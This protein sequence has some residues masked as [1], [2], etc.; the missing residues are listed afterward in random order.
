MVDVSFL[1]HRLMS[2]SWLQ[3]PIIVSVRVS[4]GSRERCFIFFVS[5]ERLHDAF[6]NQLGCVRC[7]VWV[8]KVMGMC[9]CAICVP[10]LLRIWLPE[11]DI[12][13]VRWQEVST[14]PSLSPEA[15]GIKPK[16]TVTEAVLL[17]HMSL[18]LQLIKVWLQLSQSDGDLLTHYH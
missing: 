5:P 8:S 2:L 10:W 18:H 4:S 15:S 14:E 12:V 17:C 13:A 3:W 6:A 11:A 1:V 7:H 9:T 16:E